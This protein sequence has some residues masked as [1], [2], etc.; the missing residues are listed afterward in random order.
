[1]WLGRKALILCFISVDYLFVG[2]ILLYIIHPLLNKIY[3]TCDPDMVCGDLLAATVHPAVQYSTLLYSTEWY[4]VHSTQYL[5]Y[6][7]PVSPVSRLDTVS[8]YEGVSRR[9][10]AEILVISRKIFGDLLKIFTWLGV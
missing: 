4:T 1:M 8:A 10:L 6:Q 5:Q 7:V 3:P 2:K 9:I